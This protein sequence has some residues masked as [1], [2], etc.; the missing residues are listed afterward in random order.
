MGGASE[1]RALPMAGRQPE[2]RGSVARARSGVFDL[3]DPERVRAGWQHR[4]V[5]A[6]ARAEE[7]IELY[8][9]L[10][11]EVAADPVPTG[12]PE[13]GCAGCFGA[14]GDE[15]RSIYTR[16]PGEE[17]PESSPPMAPTGSCR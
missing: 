8:R 17:P 10:G 9:E 16:R 2:V 6:G 13:D 11:F 1:G 15:Y 14:G 12:G 5:A 3:A 4:F 7:M